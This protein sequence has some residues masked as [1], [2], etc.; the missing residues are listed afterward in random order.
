MRIKKVM[1]LILSSVIAV[2]CFCFTSNANASAQGA[3]ISFESDKDVGLFSLIDSKDM[4][5]MTFK[6]SDDQSV[7]GSSLS[8]MCDLTESIV[9]GSDYEGV[10]FK[11]EGL[12][13]A[14]FSGCKVTAS[15]YFPEEAADAMTYAQIFCTGTD[16]SWEQASISIP[17]ATGKWGIAELEC[18]SDAKPTTIGFKLPVVEPY[19]GVLCYIDNVSVTDAS[20]NQIAVSDN[21]DNSTTTTEVTTTEATTTTTTPAT[22]TE[23]ITEVVDDEVIDEVA[24]DEDDEEDQPNPKAPTFSFDM[25][26]ASNYFT[27]VDAENTANISFKQATDKRISGGSL[28]VSCKNTE[29]IDN[30]VILQGVAINAADFG[31]P[32]FKGCKIIMHVYFPAEVTELMDFAQLYCTGPDGSWKQYDMNTVSGKD[33]WNYAVLTCPTDASPTV[34]GLKLP[35]SGPYEGTL[36]YIENVEIFDADGNKILNID[37]WDERSAENAVANPIEKIETP[38]LTTA[39]TTAK[40][41]NGDEGGIPK[42][43]IIII[44]IV[45]VVLIVGSIVTLI[46]VKTKKSYY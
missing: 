19:S 36:C 21:A 43:A 28:K 24:P 40:V 5:K 25:A 38:V 17:S 33:R 41:D 29:T 4:A 39:A 14:D 37:G 31:L 10:C 22:T 2:A 32:T 3:T 35:I 23:E 8:V 12:G 34:I 42:I 11:A 45:A 9:D 44:A 6:Q 16:G 20:G 15:I 1:A 26:G 13:I 18:P 7:T 27:L 30:E 46:I